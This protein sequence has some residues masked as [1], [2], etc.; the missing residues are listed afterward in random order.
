M[1]YSSCVEELGEKVSDDDDDELRNGFFVVVIRVRTVVAAGF[2]SCFFSTV[3]TRPPKNH[4]N[5]P[6]I[7]LAQ[8]CRLAFTGTFLKKITRSYFVPWL[9]SAGRTIFYEF[10]LLSAATKESF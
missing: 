2:S 5:V 3:S 8:T 1:G 4:F 10:R 7:L 6:A 9:S